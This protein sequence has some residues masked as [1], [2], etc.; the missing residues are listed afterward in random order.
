MSQTKLEIIA[1][2]KYSDIKELD[3]H[4]TVIETAYTQGFK[5]A[6]ELIEKNLI[7]ELQNLEKYFHNGERIMTLKLY[8]AKIQNMLIEMEKSYD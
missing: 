5:D 8:K 1:K 6:F 7:K 2:H 3:I 4:R